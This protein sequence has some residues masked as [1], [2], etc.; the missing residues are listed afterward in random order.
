MVAEAGSYFS[1]KADLDLVRLQALCWQTWQLLEENRSDPQMELFE[2]E[3]P[4]DI[5]DLAK[6]IRKASQ[7]NAFHLWNV[8]K[9]FGIR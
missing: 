6:P 8:H 9:A 3:A 2:W 1:I 5:G 7:G 4:N